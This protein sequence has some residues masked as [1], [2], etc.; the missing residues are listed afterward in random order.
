MFGKDNL[1][2]FADQL[3]VKLL[4]WLGSFPLSF[5]DLFLGKHRVFSGIKESGH[6]YCPSNDT[7]IQ[8]PST[9]PWIPLCCDHLCSNL[10]GERS[11]FKDIGCGTTLSQTVK[12]EQVIKTN[13]KNKQIKPLSA[14][15]NFQSGMMRFTCYYQCSVLLAGATHIPYTLSLGTE[16]LCDQ[17]GIGYSL[18]AISKPQ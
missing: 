16:V 7:L 12:L 9:C 1:Q 15:R 11:T 10:K 14:L 6:P 3:V 2:N 5:G 4:V 18:R 17:V 8:I 13:K